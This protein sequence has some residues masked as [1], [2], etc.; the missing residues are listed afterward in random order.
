MN[1]PGSISSHPLCQDFKV[2]KLCGV[3]PPHQHLSDN[4]TRLHLGHLQAPAQGPC[5]AQALKVAIL[6][7]ACPRN[8][9]IKQ[10]KKD[11]TRQGCREGHAGLIAGV[12]AIPHMEWSEA[13]PW[14]GKPIVI[15][16][17]AP[18]KGIHL[19]SS[20]NGGCQS[21]KQL[22]PFKA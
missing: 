11:A 6:Q 20:K 14:H 13:W 9:G 7:L 4:L 21:V 2:W 22:V 17:L 5:Q 15:I 12:V 10:A 3:F 1:S 16:L 8:S 18:I 19:P